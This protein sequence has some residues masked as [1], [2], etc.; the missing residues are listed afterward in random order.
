[1]PLIHLK[2]SDMCLHLLYKNNEAT[3]EGGLMMKIIP[4]SWTNLDIS[5]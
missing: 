1:M 5:K 4:P 2:S 3:G